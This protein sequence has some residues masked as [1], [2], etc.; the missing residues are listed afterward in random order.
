MVEIAPMMPVANVTALWGFSIL[1]IWV[2]M[3]SPFSTSAERTV[4]QLREKLANA[5][6]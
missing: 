2:K 6:I 5:M 4:D 3:F 1:M